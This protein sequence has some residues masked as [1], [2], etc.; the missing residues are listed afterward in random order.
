MPELAAALRRRHGAADRLPQRTEDEFRAICREDGLGAGLTET[1]VSMYRA[2]DAGEFETVSDDIRLLTGRPA[3]A[4]A[5]YL[6]EALEVWRFE[7]ST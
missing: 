6:R 5:S 7:R 2:V 4:A 3:Q 1:L